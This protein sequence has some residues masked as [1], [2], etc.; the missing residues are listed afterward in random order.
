MHYVGWR[1]E[2]IYIEDAGRRKISSDE[3]ARLLE[4]IGTEEKR[5]TLQVPKNKRN[6]V[7]TMR[8]QR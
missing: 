6:P 7:L 3:A 1:R 5:A 2:D 4:A 8:Y